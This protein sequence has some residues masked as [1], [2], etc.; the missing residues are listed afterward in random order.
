[1]DDV[2]GICYQR[3]EAVGSCFPQGL[4]DQ[5]LKLWL[6]S[7][8]AHR[9]LTMENRPSRPWSSEITAAVGSTGHSRPWWGSAL[10]FSPLT[11]VLCHLATPGGELRRST[12]PER[13][14]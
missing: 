2:S 6:E 12:P 3:G 7:A 9:T 13:S 11:C 10:D 8:A 5:E 1:M 14:P 4:C